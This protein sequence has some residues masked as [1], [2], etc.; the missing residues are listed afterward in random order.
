MVERSDSER[1]Y[2]PMDL[3]RCVHSAPGQRASAHQCLAVEWERT[4]QRCRRRDGYQFIQLSTVGTHGST[5]RS[6]QAARI[7]FKEA[8]ANGSGYKDFCSDYSDCGLARTYLSNREDSIWAG[9]FSCKLDD[10]RAD[11]PRTRAN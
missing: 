11:G 9:P 8:H 5:R 1:H 4:S 7:S 3:Y 10:L 6:G 2:L